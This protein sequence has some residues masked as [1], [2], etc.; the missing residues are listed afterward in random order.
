MS[1]IKTMADISLAMHKLSSDM[2]IMRAALKKPKPKTTKTTK[3]TSTKK[4]RHIKANT[5]KKSNTKRR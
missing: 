1:I 5:R 2:A 4:K 3:K